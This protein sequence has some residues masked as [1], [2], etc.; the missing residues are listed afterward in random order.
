MN[1]ALTPRSDHRQPDLLLPCPV[2]AAVRVLSLACAEDRGAVFTRHEVVDFILDLAGYTPDQP[3]HLLRLLEPAFGEGGFLVPAVKRLLLAWQAHGGR[4]DCAA[5]LAPCIRGFELHL[6]TFARTREA[7]LG[8][9]A[10][11]GVPAPAA[12]H[13]ASTWLT[14]GDFLSA[15]IEGAFDAGVGNPP[16][17][18]LERVPEALMAAYRARYRTLAGRADL[19]VPFYER[20]LRLLG[21]G[22]RLAFICADRWTKNSYGGP[23]RR[24]VAEGG[25]RL[26]AYVDMVGTPA[27]ESAVVAYPAITLIAREPPGPTRVAYRPR[28]E[29]GSLAT[30]AAGL[31][32]GVEAPYG[33]VRVL[34]MVP[35]GD[36]PWM[37]G[38]ADQM[39]VVSKLEAGFPALEEAGCRVG[40]GVA[41]G[42]DDVFIVPYDALDVEDGRKLP[43]VTTGDIVDGTVR[44]RGL[45]VVNPHADEP[46][47]VRLADYPRLRR[48]LEPHRERLAGRHCARKT[49]SN[50]YRTI[51][52]IHP[53]LARTPKLLIPDI[54]G[55]AHIVYEDGRLYPHHNLYFI[56]SSTWDLHALQAVLLSGIAGLFV[57]AYSTRMRGDYLRFQAQHLRRIRLP[58]WEA[59]PD[60]IRD[61]LRHTGGAADTASR[62]AAV[63]ELYGLSPAEQA[64][65]FGGRNAA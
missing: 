53:E 64:A 36:A 9:L 38:A 8:V 40:I 48:Y 14:Q 18:R 22:G 58:R 28:I 6:A 46:G 12:E 19:Y 31:A 16:Y 29:A 17:L 10:T 50:W 37:L 52:R 43:L 62:D 1:V 63:A 44:W 39:E 7:V 3:L 41:T 13:L 4:N 33:R 65:V 59:V 21:D 61:A 47:L 57:A 49:P 60:R 54:K 25:F 15:E 5:E 26:R 55:K 2:E 42:A 32:N 34:P 56:T 27:F 20:T 30:L 45:G 23:L 24:L 51:D 35:H 11:H